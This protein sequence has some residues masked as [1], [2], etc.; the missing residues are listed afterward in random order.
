MG[1]AQL[2]Y[3]CRLTLAEQKPKTSYEIG[4][5]YTPGQVDMQERLPFPPIPYIRTDETYKPGII[6]TPKEGLKT[7]YSTWTRRKL[8]IKYL[9]C[10]YA[11]GHICF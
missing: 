9:F 5:A 2:D 11:C 3:N 4:L 10:F 6:Y 8:F 1:D 7:T